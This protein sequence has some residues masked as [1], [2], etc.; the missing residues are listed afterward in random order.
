MATH[1]NKGQA[2]VQ[3]LTRMEPPSVKS[4]LM[5]DD[6]KICSSGLYVTNWACDSLHSHY[7]SCDG[8][9]CNLRAC[10]LMQH[11]TQCAY[12]AEVLCRLNLACAA[13]SICCGSFKCYV[14]IRY[15]V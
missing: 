5:T 10:N 7:S 14:S 13:R 1:H 2:A 4:K 8:K 3:A 11:I 15:F 6:E 9:G 12:K